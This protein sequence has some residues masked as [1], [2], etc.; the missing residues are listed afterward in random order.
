MEKEK[1]KFNKKELLKLPQREWDTESVYDSILLVP[2][3]TKHD[4]GYMHIAIV[5]IRE[6]KP[7]EIAA[8]P[9][10]ISWVTPS[11][12]RPGLSFPLAHM[13][14]DCYY[15]SGIIRFHSTECDFQVSESLSSVDIT[16]VPRIK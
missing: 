13:R 3:G 12:M 7:V 14:T 10:D 6:G 15:P 4:S 5:G 8:Y 11:S 16:L 1:E 9:D 2:A